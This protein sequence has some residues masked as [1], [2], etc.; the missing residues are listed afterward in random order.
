MDFSNGRGELA[1][2]L[3]LSAHGGLKRKNQSGL[4]VIDRRSVSL[5]SRSDLCG[6][7]C[8]FY[9]VELS[10]RIPRVARDVRRD[11][12]AAFDAFEPVTVGFDAAVV[13]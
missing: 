12:R 10:V 1:A 3:K 2:E 13:P 4:F 11:A 6:M 9:H 8:V 5:G 7:D